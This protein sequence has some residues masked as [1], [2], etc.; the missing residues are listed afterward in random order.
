M[1][2]GRCA[3]PDASAAGINYAGARRQGIMSV[4]P[5]DVRG[6]K[7][8]GEIPAHLNITGTCR[9]GDD[10]AR[11]N[12]SYEKRRKELARKKKREEKR[13][14]KLAKKNPP[15]EDT[16]DRAPDDTPLT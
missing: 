8:A 6:P 14:R 12:Y 3:K 9:K 13:L 15:P 16:S 1:G 7:A 10:L 4:D 11:T 2:T 5:R